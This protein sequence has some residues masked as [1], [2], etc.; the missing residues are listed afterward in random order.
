MYCVVSCVQMARGAAVLGSPCP[1]GYSELV[2]GPSIRL[3][4]EELF[5][6]RI[7]EILGKMY[8][9]VDESST[10]S[11][12]MTCGVIALDVCSFRMNPKDDR[13]TLAFRIPHARIT[14]S[15]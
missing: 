12:A 6:L 15:G 4:G 14:R 9:S 13:E 8:A 5:K 2:P 7:P 10:C 11:C 3:T 1:S